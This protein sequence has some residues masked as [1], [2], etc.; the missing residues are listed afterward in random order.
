MLI[1]SAD[2]VVK[3]LPMGEAIEAMKGAYAALSTGKADVPLRTR[4]P[5]E[6]SEGLALFMPAHLQEG[7][8]AA[9]AVKVVSVFNQNPAKGLPLI[10]AAVLV[11]D[12][13][14]GTVQALLEGGSLTAIRTGAASGAATDLLARPNAS[15]VGILG[16]GVQART[17]LL[18]VCE[19]RAI[20]T[21][22]VYSPDTPG[23]EA[24]VAEMKG[25]SPIPQDL[26]AA[27]SSTEAVQAADIVC[28][29]TTSSQPV[30]AD[31][32]LKAGAHVNG[33]G[34]YT[35]EMQEVPG[36]TVERALVVVD[37][38]SAAMVECGDVTIPVK[39]G[40][41]KESDIIE[42]GELAAGLKPGRESNEQITFFKSVG[43]AVQDAA[44]GRLAYENAL[45][46]GLGTEVDL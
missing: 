45:R 15:T 39:E 22:W 33:V 19:V 12:S 16:A 3:A 44:A 43:V 30:F 8:E 20:E 37:S 24:F 21:A 27:S 46:L 2:E 14:N 13:Q 17:Q 1:L 23:V 26:R 7:D 38:R 9:L 40:R 34:S 36:E 11:L 28:T 29:A 31:A 32:D 4:I 18:A 6:A 41:I 10:H 42:I 25:K 5:V 35:L